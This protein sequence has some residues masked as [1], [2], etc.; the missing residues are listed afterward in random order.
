MKR[1]WITCTNNQTG[2]LHFGDV[3]EGNYHF[4]VKNTGNN[5]ADLSINSVYVLY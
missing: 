1:D 2:Y 3:Q 5:N 4:T